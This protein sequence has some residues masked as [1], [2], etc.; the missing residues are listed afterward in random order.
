MLATWLRS[1]TIVNMS[2]PGEVFL[3]GT[4][5]QEIEKPTIDLAQ[6]AIGSEV[7]MVLGEGADCERLA[8]LRLRFTSPP[9]DRQYGKFEVTEAELDPE[10]IRLNTKADMPH[11]EL[12]GGEIWI[13]FA[14]TYRRGYMP[15]ITMAERDVITPGRHLF[16]GIPKPAAGH[17][18]RYIEY[19][20]EVLDAQV[21]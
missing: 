6:L 3:D 9:D 4:V 15:P 20:A 16:I 1:S 2:V 19:H 14:C 8:R 12:M 21:I 10:I 7:A 17:P 5:R 18:N 13:Q 11:P